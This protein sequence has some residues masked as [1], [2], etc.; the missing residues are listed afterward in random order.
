MRRRIRRIR[1]GGLRPLGALVAI[2]AVVPPTGLVLRTAAAE[3]AP[4]EARYRVLA[5]GITILEIDALIELSPVGYRLSTVTRTRGPADLAIRGEQRAE[6]AGAFRGTDPLP[7]RYRSVGIW[8]GR[9]RQVDIEFRGADPVLRAQ[10]PP[11]DGTEREPVPPELRRGTLD[12]LSA[13]VKLAR[14]VGATG[15]CEGDAAVFDGRRRTDYVLSTA[16]RDTLPRW[17]DAWAG[18]ALRC[19]FEG[20]QIAGF[21]RDQDLAERGRPQRGTA[22]VAPLAPG[23]PPVPV[24]LELPTR[25]LGNL[26]AY[27]VAIAPPAR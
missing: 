3:A 27:L 11:D 16:G 19:G 8:R 23:G 25:W 10:V 20:R 6:A 24:R 14:I 12:A 18:E 15:R 5:A 22:W 13:L 4:I 26:Q 17:R 21:H 1:A 2:A 7:F 9:P